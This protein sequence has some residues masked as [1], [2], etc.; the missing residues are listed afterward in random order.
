MIRA[1]TPA[2]SEFVAAPRVEPPATLDAFR[3]EASYLGADHGR[4]ERRVWV[5]SAICAVMLAVQLAGG[6][7]FH[8]MALTAGGLHMA[9]HV[10]VLVTA[11][12][13]YRLARRLAADPRFAF[14]AGKISYLAGFA[15]AVVLAITG[16]GIG[17]ESLQRLVSPEAVDYASALPLAAAGLVLNLLCMALLKPTRL[18]HRHDEV[19]D[20]N[21]SAAHLHLSADA[22]ISLLT[23]GGLFAGQR[24]GWA[25]ADPLLGLLGAALV[26]QFAFT[27]VRQAGAT[28]LDVNPSP[29]LTAEIAKRLAAAGAEV[30]D[31]HVWR[32]GPGHHAAIAVLAA[33]TPQPV[34]RYRA[35]LAD[36]PGLSHLTVEVRS[37]GG[38]R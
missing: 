19:G 24:L 1:A 32:L 22:A 3:S 21:L 17:V 18:A 12:A 25:F 33:E 2:P 37:L 20:L 10:A 36:V 15:N 34:E 4:N 35:A 5:V 6:A 8:S 14:G 38:A 27:L 7:L 31:L 11:A 28:L 9:A 26:G 13:A 30:L 16:V 23:I 29:A